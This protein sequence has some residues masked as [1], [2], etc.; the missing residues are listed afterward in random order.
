M[1]SESKPVGAGQWMVS[2]G[3]Q[4]T[5]PFPLDEMKQM[6]RDGRLSPASLVWTP[7]MTEWKP[8]KQVPDLGGTETAAAGPTHAPASGNSLAASFGDKAVIG[9]YLFFRKM[10][11]PLI[12]QAVFWMAVAAV[13]IGSLISLFSAFATRSILGVIIGLF[14]SFLMFALGVIVVRIYCELVILAFRI[15]DTL[16]DIKGLLEKKQ[17]DKVTRT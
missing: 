11:T 3:G 1:S 10:I 6:A 13:A 4:Q 12:I 17:G 7:G 2:E 5:G 15:L 8:W 14:V 16:T 9:D